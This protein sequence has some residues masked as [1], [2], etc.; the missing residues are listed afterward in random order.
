MT[1]EEMERLVSRDD[2][3]VCT[4]SPGT[5]VITDTCGYH[6]GGKPVDGNRLLWTAQYTSGAPRAGRNFDLDDDDGA[7]A[8]LPTDQRY[9]LVEKVPLL[10]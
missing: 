4:G 1:D 5:V 6:K 9:A 3:V 8:A 10:A 7:A 2:W